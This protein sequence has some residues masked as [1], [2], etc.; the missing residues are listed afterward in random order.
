MYHILVVDDEVRIRSIIKKY[1]EFD[2]HSITEAADGME[3]VR[4]TR[5]TDFDIII[6]AVGSNDRM[7]ESAEITDAQFVKDGAFIPLEDADRKTW[8]GSIRYV[9]ESLY[10]LYPNAV[11]F[12]CTPIQADE[13][14]E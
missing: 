5:A 2:G 13:K 1:A 6:M 10:D 8:G 4:L 11:Q 12:I 14:I 7:P 3:A 9:S